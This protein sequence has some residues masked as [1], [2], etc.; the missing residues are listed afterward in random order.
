L[1]SYLCGLLIAAAVVG[2]WASQEMILRFVK[3][4]SRAIRRGAG[5]TLSIYLFHHPLMLATS[6]TLDSMARGP[7][8]TYHL[9]Y[10][11][12]FLPTFVFERQRY[13]LRKLLPRAFGPTIANRAIC[14]AANAR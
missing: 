11:D 9:N 2:A 7:A 1:V 12:A 13:P 10:A 3:P 14:F 4:F 5:L 8:R 6:A